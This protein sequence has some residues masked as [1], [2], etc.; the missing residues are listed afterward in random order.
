MDERTRETIPVPTKGLLAG[1]A[2]GA[3]SLR[4][5]ADDGTPQKKRL[6]FSDL[7]KATQASPGSIGKRDGKALQARLWNTTNPQTGMVTKNIAI[8]INPAAGCNQQFID[9]VAPLLL[10]RDIGG[11][12]MSRVAI[13]AVSLHR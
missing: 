4:S 5:M 13:S 9:A 6:K 3:A 7:G 11:S 10:G 2:R 8:T 12:V 1:F